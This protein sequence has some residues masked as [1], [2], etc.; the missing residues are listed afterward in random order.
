MRMTK[1]VALLGVIAFAGT[2]LS[3]AGI[4]IKKAQA[5]L[6]LAVV[7]GA[8]ATPGAPIYWEGSRVTTA[9]AKGNFLFSGMVPSDCVGTLTDGVQT[10]QVT[11][12]TDKKSSFVECRPGAPVMQTGQTVTYTPND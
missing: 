7:Q 11:I 12:K 10:V 3:A 6:G 2:V 8:K 1:F 9:D 5:V 4:Q